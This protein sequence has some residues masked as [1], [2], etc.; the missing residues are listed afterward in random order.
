MK[1]LDRLDIS[2]SLSLASSAKDTFTIGTPLENNDGNIDNLIVHA[3]ADFRNNV[4]LGSSFVDT[5]TIN[6][7]I[8]PSTSGTIVLGSSDKPFK[9]LYVSSASLIVASDTPGNPATIISNVSGNLKFD[10]GGLSVPGAITASN[11]F[12]GDGA[13]VTGIIASHVKHQYVN[14]TASSYTISIIDGSPTIFYINDGSANVYLPDAVANDSI[15]ITIK[16]IGSQTITIHPSGSQKINAGTTHTIIKDKA[17][18]FHAMS[19]S[20]G[21]AWQTLLS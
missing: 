20:A 7:D 5:I 2:G 17:E 4:I 14:T 12:V 3:N 6:C 21:Y 1:I 11:G 15:M 8:I 9:G 10:R 16:N 19:S 18:I 13:K